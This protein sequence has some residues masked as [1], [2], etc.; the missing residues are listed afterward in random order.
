MWGKAG[1]G[2]PP[3]TGFYWNPWQCTFIHCISVMNWFPLINSVAVQSGMPRLQEKSCDISSHCVRGC[4]PGLQI[5][6]QLA[7]VTL[8][9]QTYFCSDISHFWPDKHWG[10]L[11]AIEVPPLP[12]TWCLNVKQV[13]FQSIYCTWA[14]ISMQEKWN[15]WYSKISFTFVR[16]TIASVLYT[17]SYEV[18]EIDWGLQSSWFSS[19]KINTS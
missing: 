7:P 14:S 1:G 16:T 18:D 2:I 12:F 4:G 17:V 15:A 19:K 9:G 6:S 8:S 13:N 5:I 11:I 3:V 10:R